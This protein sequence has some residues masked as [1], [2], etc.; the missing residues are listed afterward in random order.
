MSINKVNTTV[1]EQSFKFLT[2]QSSI[3]HTVETNNITVNGVNVIVEKPKRGDVM[4]ITHYERDGVLLD[5]DK[6]KVVW[7]DG[8]SINPKQLSQEYE[9]VGICLVVKGNKVIV[10]YREEK[11]LYWADTQRF[12]L[13]NS[14][15]MNDGAEHTLKITLNKVENPNPLVL[16][17]D[18]TM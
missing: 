11:S 16:T 12:E 13:P 1:E 4:C 18:D 3:L 6:Q 15:I 7:I 2:N 17:S 8:L 5:A 10:R 14:S 9:P